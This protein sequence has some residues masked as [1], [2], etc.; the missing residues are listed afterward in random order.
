M[1]T[2]CESKTLCPQSWIIPLNTLDWKNIIFNNYNSD[3]QC[4]GCLLLGTLFFD[5]KR[6]SHRHLLRRAALLSW[7][8]PNLPQ[9]QSS[10]SSSGS[11]KTHP[12]V[13]QFS[14]NCKQIVGHVNRCVALCY[15]TYVMTR[16]RG[17][18]ERESRAMTSIQ[19]AGDKKPS[20]LQT[21]ERTLCNI[22]ALAG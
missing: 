20:R 10:L 15:C 22:K 6:C 21:R 1:G 14:A 9:C 5:R 11:G 3:K 8:S 18:W 2:K 7:N 13:G 17:S 4:V 16:N 19:Y 12:A